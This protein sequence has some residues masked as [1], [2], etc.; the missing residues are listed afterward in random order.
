MGIGSGTCLLNN[1]KSHQDK[2]KQH[3]AMKV[4]RNE[5]LVLNQCTED[6]FSLLEVA[7][8]MGSGIKSYTECWVRNSAAVTQQS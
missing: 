7:V 4:K 6:M 2:Q 3:R 1:I 5:L 8:D